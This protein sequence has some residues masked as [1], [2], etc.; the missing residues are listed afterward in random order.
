M[1]ALGSLPDVVASTPFILNQVM[2]STASG[3]SGVVMHGID[4]AFAPQVTDIQKFLREG[5]LAQLDGEVETAE[6]AKIPGII[7]GRELARSLAVSPGAALTVVSP[8]GLLSPTGMMPRWKKFQVV[9]LFESGMYEYDTSMAYIS[10]A[11][12]Q[13]FFKMG[14]TVTGLEV[15]V[16]DIYATDG[17]ARQISDLA[18]PGYQVR[19]WKDM[20]RNLYSALRLEKLAMFVILA[21][22]I[23]VAAF[24]IVATLVMMVNDKNR[25]IAIL[26][27]MGATTGAIKRIF[28]LQG[29]IIGI[30]GT[31]LGLAGGL[32]LAWLQNTHEIVKLA[33]DVYY[34]P[35][36]T[37]KISTID[38][39]LVALCAVV[40]CFLATIYPAGQAAKLEPAEALRYE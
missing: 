22:I 19:D 1:H 33:K 20:H 40:I 16:K 31:A 13:S 35:A 37:V 29:L 18:G 12:A 8:S 25:E 14:D 3:V 36:L 34:I 10:I 38:S 4:T 21:L 30:I 23:L 26:K 6:G 27:S 17:V 9:G 11:S 5:E 15:K 28:M 24:S 7:I 39:V 2:L 32:A